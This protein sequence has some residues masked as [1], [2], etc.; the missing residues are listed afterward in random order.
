MLDTNLIWELVKELTK[1]FSKGTMP[2]KGVITN[3]LADPDQDGEP[4]STHVEE[5]IEKCE[6]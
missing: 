2:P 4:L 6:D 3:G 1:H 5:E